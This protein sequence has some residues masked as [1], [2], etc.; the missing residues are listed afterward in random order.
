MLD[1]APDIWKKGFQ[2]EFTVQLSTVYLHLGSRP[3]AYISTLC[4]RC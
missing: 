4:S 3:Q 1:T 2:E